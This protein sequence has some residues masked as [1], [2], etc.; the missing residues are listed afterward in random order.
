MDGW[1]LFGGALILAAALLEA[2]RDLKSP[3]YEIEAGAA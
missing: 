1:E 2:L 3:P